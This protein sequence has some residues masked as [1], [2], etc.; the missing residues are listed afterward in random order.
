MRRLIINAD[1]LGLTTGVNRAII[2]SHE[3]GVLTSATLMANSQAFED[4]ISAVRGLSTHSLSVG[5]HLVLVDG[6]PVSSPS[7]VPSLAPNGEFRRTLGE[8]A[9]ASLAGNLAEAE[10]ESEARAQFRAIQDSGVVLS[11]FDAHKH[12][13]MFPA[14]LAP[15]L[16]A[17]SACGIPAVRN[18]FEPSG[19]ILLPALLRQPGLFK[20]YAQV[21]LL[22]S[23]RSGWLRRVRESGLKTPDGALGVIVTGALDES[24]LADTL[25][26]MPE[27]TWELVC[28][29]GY[30]DR[31]LAGIRT[32]LRASRE[33]ELE[34][35]TSSHT[36]ALL[37]QLGIQLISYREL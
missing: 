26:N 1:D 16:R 13:H 27:G 21:A 34:L 10:I 30:D 25:R 11:H 32:R 28:H 6:K 36:R 7:A 19:L 29:P 2:Q 20:R 15:A 18:P 35:L 31:E 33:K 9:R 22:R 12:A 23:M 4:A 37:E 8:L 14:V 5:C 3:S 24:L 17:A